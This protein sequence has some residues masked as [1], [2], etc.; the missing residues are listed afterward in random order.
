MV[1]SGFPEEILEDE[2]E[3]SLEGALYIFEDPLVRSVDLHQNIVHVVF[4]ER[5]DAASIQRE[6]QHVAIVL[7]MDNA[8]ITD[9]WDVPVPVIS[10][11]GKEAELWES[12]QHDGCWDFTLPIDT[13]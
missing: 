7:S 3:K 6:V 10:G 13:D 11:E 2:L 9:V 12:R 4:Q 5:A 1:D 8:Y